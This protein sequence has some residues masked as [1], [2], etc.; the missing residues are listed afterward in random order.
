MLQKYKIP[1]PQNFAS[2]F[3]FNVPIIVYF[4]LYE[5]RERHSRFGLIHQ[6]NRT[7][8]SGIPR[9]ASTAGRC[10]PTGKIRLSKSYME[11]WSAV[12]YVVTYNGKEKKRFIGD[13]NHPDPRAAEA[14][15]K[16][17]NEE[18]KAG[19]GIIFGD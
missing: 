8:S 7:R 13:Q 17:L 14:T 1:P 15:N 5:N 2:E 10:S 9:R 19:T 12:G 11:P 16:L 18:N 3:L 4:A 6:R